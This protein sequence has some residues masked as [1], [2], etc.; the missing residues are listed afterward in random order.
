LI[1]VRTQVE[2]KVQLATYGSFDSLLVII[3]HGSSA[4]ITFVDG[5]TSGNGMAQLLDPK[6]PSRPPST[7]I[8]LACETG[9]ANFGREFSKASW[10]QDYIASFHA[11]N[12]AA[13]SQFCQSLLTWHL[14]DG[15]G[16]DAAHRR[17]AASVP[18]GPSFRRWR[19]GA[20]A[21]SRYS[22]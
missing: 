21:A 11:V 8:S 9:A 6:D 7:V 16:M 19:N 18:S 4:S 20:I 13:A 10:C 15:F 3:G 22:P 14:L 1:N 2:L 17:A 5:A 12:G